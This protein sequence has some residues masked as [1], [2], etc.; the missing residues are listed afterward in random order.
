M[1]RKSYKGLIIGVLV[2]AVLIIALPLLLPNLNADSCTRLIM[3]LIAV[4][5]AALTFAVWLTE[6]VYWYNNTPFEDAEKAGSE[7]RKA[8]A[9]CHF[10][11]FGI[12]AAASVLYACAAWLLALPWWVDMTLIGGGLIVCAFWSMKY[13]L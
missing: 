11:L 4:G 12:F 8:F 9:L 2:Y 10:R 3:L 1:Y 7:R 6:Q 5:M 13:K